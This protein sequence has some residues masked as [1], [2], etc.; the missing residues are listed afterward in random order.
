MTR[1]I[2]AVA[3][4]VSFFAGAMVDHVFRGPGMPPGGPHGGPGGPGGYIASQ[5]GLT[6]DQQA[7]MKD[8]WQ[9]TFRRSGPENHAKRDELRHQQEQSIAAL[10]R[11]E[12]K[13]A[14]DK[15]LAD[16]KSKM[17][18]MDADGKKAFDEAVSKTKQIL[19]PDQLKKYEQIIQR[20][21]DH[22]DH[23]RP[24]TRPGDR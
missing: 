23:D 15:I 11:P 2:V 22:H 4:I 18:A 19:T 5:L 13:P 9:N 16:T 6:A 7:K 8:I 21:W 14:Y 17:D 20:P 10:I 24:A 12:D 1:L 3:V